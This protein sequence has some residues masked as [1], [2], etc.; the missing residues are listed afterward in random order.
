LI[1]AKNVKQEEICAL[2]QSQL[3]SNFQQLSVS[4][5]NTIAIVKE[6][7]STIEQNQTM[8][9]Y[10]KNCKNLRAIFTDQ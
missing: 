5:P 10:L 9:L 8:Q 7:E 1:A 6:F 2:E 3:V 4:Q